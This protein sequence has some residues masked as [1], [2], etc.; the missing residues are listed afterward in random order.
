[1]KR[2]N[3]MKHIF[4]TSTVF[5]FAL[6]II[7]III[8]RNNI[9]RSINTFLAPM[10]FILVLFKGLW[11]YGT[12]DEDHLLF[13]RWHG[14]SRFYKYNRP[15]QKQL[16]DFYFKATI[17]FAALPFYLPLAV[18]SSKDIHSLWTLLL[19]F[20]PQL[21][22][23]GMGINKTLKDVKSSKQKQEHLE[24]ERKEQERKEELGPWK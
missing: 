10:F 8:F 24:K 15:T 18:F 20:L 12:K 19:L 17:Y 9:S 2:K 14:P 22:F 23:I 6:N 1:M 21:A 3:N 16:N 11:A 4:W 5:L 13:K 7:G